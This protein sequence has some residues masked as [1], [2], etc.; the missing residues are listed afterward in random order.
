MSKVTP[1]SLF[2]YHIKQHYQN[3]TKPPLRQ[4]SDQGVIKYTM[5]YSNMR[6]MYLQY[7]KILEKK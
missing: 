3:R 6:Y 7:M 1:I 4:K 5:C 2:I